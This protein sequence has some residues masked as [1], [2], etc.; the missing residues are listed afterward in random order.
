MSRPY[1]QG[2]RGR[3]GGGDRGARGG[4]G[5]RGSGDR[6]G[7]GGGR[8]GSSSMP[9]EVFRDPSGSIPQPSSDVTA[10]ENK[11]M[12]A[13]SGISGSL[14][15]TR[16]T[17]TLPLR[18]GHGSQGTPITV[19][20]NYFEVK[21]QTKLSLYRYNV[22]IAKIG[23]APVPSKRKLQRLFQL[24]LEDPRFKGTRSDFSSMLI[25]TKRLANTPMDI[26]IPFRAVGEDTPSDN[27]H[28]Y[29]YTIQE[30]G[31]IP[32]SEFQQYLNSVVA[33]VP[34][35]PQRDE[36]LQALNAVIGHHAQSRDD[37]AKIGQNKYYSLDRT[38]QNLINIKDLGV[39]MELLRGVF[40]S[41]RPATSR[42]L[43]NVNVSHAAC[44]E[45]G[46]L[47]SLM[48]K[49]GNDHKLSLAKNLKLVRIQRTHLPEKRNQA[50]KI[51]LGVKTIGDLATA[52]DGFDS[53]HPPQVR[54]FG[55]GPKDVNFF[56]ESTEK[57]RGGKPAAK[58]TSGRYISVWDYF[59]QNYK[60]IKMDPKL[61]V[62]NVGNRQRPSYL[63]AEAC[64]VLP[65]QPMGGKLS[66][67]QTRRMIEFACRP[68]KANADFIV[69]PGKDVLGLSRSP[70]N[71]VNQ[72]G[73]S[74]GQS[75]ITVAARILTPPRIQYLDLKMKPKTVNPTFGS[76]N[77]LDIKFHKSGRKIDP[78]TFVWIRSDR[79]TNQG[80]QTDN[81]VLATVRKFVEFMQRTG[82]DIGPP[83]SADIVPRTLHLVDNDEQT[84]N[85]NIGLM[86]HDMIER[87]KNKLKF[88]LFI[89]PYND[90]AIYRK[91]KTVAD[92][93]AGIH[94][95]CVVGTKFAKEA[96]QEQYFA[97]VALKFNL[98]AGGINQTIEPQK[99]GIIGEG[100]TMVVG[101][102]VTH[103]QPGSK[104]GAPS[105]A[106]IVASTDRYLGQWPADIR[107][108]KSRKEMVTDLKD[109]FSSRLDLWRA[110][111]GSLPEN[112]LV[113]RDGVSEGQYQI[114][115]DEELPLLRQACKG[116]YAAN[117]TTKGLPAIT[118]I[119]VG[120]RHHTRFYPVKES[121]ADRSANCKNG[122]VV[123]RGVTE[124]RNWNFF[125]QAHTCLQ[126]TAR[127][128]HYYI[129]LD[130]I[131][132]GK[133]P[134]NPAHKNAADVVEDLTHNM[135]HLFG[136]ATKAVS[137]CPPAYYADLL[138]ERARCYLSHVFEPATPGH[139]PADSVAGSEAHSSAQPDDVEIQAD[140][141]DSM[142]YI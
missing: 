39:G 121:E 21:I 96:R 7:R 123:D 70:T 117:Q 86:F 4:G 100:K 17:N 106:G 84:N 15:N 27:P 54:G 130:E 104:E 38:T 67:D 12:Q 73:L 66:P 59:T 110:R 36:I 75:L 37:I 85:S 107:I 131:F 114:V 111:N 79:R 76:W 138:C 30:T 5:Y 42:L 97:N 22:A 34:V 32:V 16:L 57:G 63:P 49:L 53:Q 113:Y 98:K 13:S 109:L 126:G 139:T 103:P 137:I 141:R 61:P 71:A 55:A 26:I 29:Q 23:S 1:G 140:L 14:A 122:T 135:C 33:G 50:G 46:P 118:I 69:G 101:I 44:Y 6:G 78:W 28:Q 64:R 119:I 20:A 60:A 132:R 9:V 92:T 82:I 11:W 41:V 134:K 83:I 25:S 51:I 24:L 65:G 87:L 35:F 124:V 40:K 115:L 31:T 45:P 2:G 56:L 129:I 58:A 91:I 127:P 93:R 19:Y 95:V 125:L 48:R 120:K 142:F 8:G 105:V 89:L 68:P 77:M 112:V 99:L 128:A 43:L 133:K 81:E 10:T 74:V 90:A 52:N 94:T 80:F 88:V 18:P 47:D 62:V 116:K 136:R 3:G 102:D 108:Q 72:Y